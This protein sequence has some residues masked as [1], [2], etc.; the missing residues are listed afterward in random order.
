MI[1]NALVYCF[2]EARLAK[3]GRS[4]LEHTKYV[5]QVSTIM[6]LLTSR[7]SDLSS[8]F[9]KSGEGAL[10]DDYLLK[11]ILINSHIGANK[12]KYKG[13]LELELIFR[14]SKTCKKITKNIGF[15]QTFK[16]V[17]LQDKLFTTIATDINVTIS[18][19]LLYVP[20]LIPN[21]E[22]QYMFN[23]SIMKNCTITFDY[24]Y[25]ERKT[26]N[27]GRE[28]QVDIGS[29]QQIN[30]PKYLIR[31]F[32]TQNRIG[33]PNKEKNIAIFD[34]SPVTKNSVEIDGTC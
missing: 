10:N 2:K 34:T 13:K 29:A 33:V 30:S 16:T 18:N 25:A 17:N 26:S 9:V 12:G 31:V 7:D 27:V 22:T 1:N 4:V 28:L 5:R 11:R 19:L 6:R 21:T 32:Q 8:F 23:E 20:T 24:W 3:T 14:F 15:H